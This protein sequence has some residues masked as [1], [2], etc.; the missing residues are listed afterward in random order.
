MAADQVVWRVLLNNF[1]LEFGGAQSDWLVISAYYWAIFTAQWCLFTDHASRSSGAV[2]KSRWPSFVVQYC[3]T[4][5]ETVRT[6]RDG[7]PRTATSTSTQ[8]LRSMRGFTEVTS[9]FT[10][11]ETVWTVRDGEPRTSTSTFTQLLS[12]NEEGLVVLYVHRDRTEH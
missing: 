4:S 1:H 9:C 8:L 2:R 6:I 11:T 10:S 5:T 7:E 12:S 3:F